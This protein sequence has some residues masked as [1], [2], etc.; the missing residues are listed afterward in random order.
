MAIRTFMSPIL[1]N[2]PNDTPLGGDAQ[3]LVA[4][5]YTRKNVTN[6]IELQDWGVSSDQVLNI[7]SQSSGVGA[8]KVVFNEF[9]TSRPADRL[10]QQLFTNEAAGVPFKW[11]DILIVNDQAQ[12]SGAAGASLKPY[13]AYRFLLV[14]ISHIASAP[15]DTYV[16]EDVSFQFGG[17]LNGYQ[18]LRADG[19]LGAF[20]PTGWDRVHNVAISGSSTV[21]T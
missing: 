21:I 10:T 2:S 15:S 9:T 4:D 12:P 16:R 13:L 7:G 11:L 1:F 20:A 14:G 19:S 5:P 18:P 6:P 17:W 3:V 8:G